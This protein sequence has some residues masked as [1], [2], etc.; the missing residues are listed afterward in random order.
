MSD[1]TFSDAVA[2]PYDAPP[3]S[4]TDGEDRTIEVRAH[5]G[6]DEELEALVEMYD[7]F[8]PRTARRASRRAAR[9]AS[10]TGWR[11]SSTRTA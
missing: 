10:A 2:D 4:F 1:R 7:A 9:T 8:D 6:S 5:D 3:L 11:T